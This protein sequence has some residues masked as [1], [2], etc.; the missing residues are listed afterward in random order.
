MMQY[1]QEEY[2]TFLDDYIHIITNHNYEI[3]DVY[4]FVQSRRNNQN[5]CELSKCNVAERHQRDKEQHDNEA[6]G[7]VDATVIFWRDIMD[8]CHCYFYHSDY[9]DLQRFQRSS[10]GGHVSNA[11][12]YERSKFIIQQH[13]D[14]DINSDT[15]F[16]DGLFEYMKQKNVMIAYLS[17]IKGILDL[18]EYDT[19]SLIMDFFNI[20]SDKQSNIRVLLKNDSSCGL[21]YGYIRGMSINA[22]IRTASFSSFKIGYRF[23]YWEYYKNRDETYKNVQVQQN[24]NN[25]SGY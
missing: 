1:F 25:H 14:I 9:F 22:S 2:K 7:S 6:N 8:S 5:S 23:Y 4:T 20:Q 15:T 19:D 17:K 21:L 24:I 16:M 13:T 3:Q 11:H 10:S 12:K 18:E